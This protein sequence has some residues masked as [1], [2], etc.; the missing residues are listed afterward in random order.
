M[1]SITTSVGDFLKMAQNRN[2][3][4]LILFVEQR[5][6]DSC[7]GCDGDTPSLLLH[8]R[9]PGS[10]SAH[11]SVD[12]VVKIDSSSFVFLLRHEGDICLCG[13]PNR[14]VVKIELGPIMQFS[15]RRIR[16]LP[17]QHESLMLLV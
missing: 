5:L 4:R 7:K 13:S 12:T 14:L 2:A 17:D 8:S 9:R 11:I 6:F 3:D 15:F 16:K 10:C 1:D